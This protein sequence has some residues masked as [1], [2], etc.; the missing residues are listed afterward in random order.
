MP[1]S[2][3]AC[4]RHLVI[5]DFANLDPV[6]EQLGTLLFEPCHV[7]DFEREEIKRAR[8]AETAIDTRIVFGRNSR[9]VAVFHEGEQLV[10]SGIEEDMANLSAF[11]HADSVAAHRLEAEHSFVKL[12]SLVEVQSR[13]PDVRES[14]V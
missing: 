10:P 3:P 2:D 11:F 13:E 7:P 5:N 14:F 8:N 6:D 1:R 9:D 12:A 4:A